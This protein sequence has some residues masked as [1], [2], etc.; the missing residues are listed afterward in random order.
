MKY[1][2]EEKEEVLRTLNVSENGLSGARAAQE[3]VIR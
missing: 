1:Y 3:G 2:C